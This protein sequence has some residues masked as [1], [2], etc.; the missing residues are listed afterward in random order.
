MAMGR[1]TRQALALLPAW[2]GLAWASAAAPNAPAS[3]PATAQ[4]QA[5]PASEQ[6]A[7]G[8]PKPPPARETVA[9]AGLA[10]MSLEELGALPVTSVSRRAQPL[11]DAAAAIFVISSDDIRRSGATSLPEVLRLAPNLQVAQLNNGRYAITARGFSGPEANKL[12]VLI[13]GRSVYTPLFAGV[14]W[15][16]VFVML[17]DVERI[18]VVSGPGGTL[19]GVNAVNGVINIITRSAQDTRGSLVAAGTGNR[20]SQ[21][22]MRH[23]VAL[24]D[25][26]SL[27]VYAQRFNESH[28]KLASGD[29]VDDG[30]QVAQAGFRADMNAVRTKLSV[31]GDLYH[32][33]QAQAAPGLFNITGVPVDLQHVRLRGANLTARWARIFDD[34]GEFT[35]QG[36]FDRAERFVPTTFQQRL[37]LSDIQIQYA[38]PPSATQAWV[39]GGEYRMAQDDLVN[40]PFISFQPGSST[41]TWS[42][43]FAQD[44]ISLRADLHLVLGSRW[45]RN[46]YTGAE[47]LPNARLAWKPTEDHL[48]WTAVSRTVRA[49]SR[50]DR[51]AYIPWP[52]AYL[53]WSNYGLGPQRPYLLAGGPGVQSEVARVFE[54]GYRGQPSSQL[55]F[56]VNVFRAL[57]DKLHTEEFM[58]GTQGLLEFDG[59]MKGAVS[60]IES[61]LTWQPLASWPHWRLSGGFTGMYQRFELYPGSRDLTDM[62]K[63]MGRDPAQTWQLRSSW[64]LS[65]GHELDAMVRHV[66]RLSN[67]D[68]PAYMALDIRWGWR[69]S[70][71]LEVSLACRNLLG[72]GHG[73]YYPIASRSEL[74]R[75]AYVQLLTRF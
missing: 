65:R 1:P 40:T 25:E 22:A 53:N 38:A 28:T 12:L 14:F 58:Q 43:L 33:D 4:P 21:L 19:W 70:P 16:S 75:S 52:S 2:L 55:S 5:L 34:E 3:P 46:D 60:G 32:S 69:V 51:E 59:K 50:I 11:S 68:V 7:P 35:V 15:D 8:Q 20:G 56:S 30:W 64:D 63:A 9:A 54:I 71:L 31:H 41:Q 67:P 6:Q 73:E 24:N 61:W 44:D 10:D 18:E 17:Q 62:P 47:W 39:I 49:P 23:G 29:R 13:D 36:Y 42:S 45:E 66:S 27:R 74:G 26:T 48:L 37:D 57:Y 72:S